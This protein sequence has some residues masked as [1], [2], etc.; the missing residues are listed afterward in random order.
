M[1]PLGSV[2]DMADPRDDGPDP[3]SRRP[4]VI[5]LVVVLAL[6]VIAY[7]LVNALRKNANLEDCLMSGRSNCA[8]IE[9][10]AS[11]R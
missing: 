3:D 11:G 8:P 4:A 9:A 5:G 1:E 7:F 2:L 6:V 10:P